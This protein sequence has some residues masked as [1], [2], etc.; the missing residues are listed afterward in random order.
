MNY[1][2]VKLIIFLFLCANSIFASSFANDLYIGVATANITPPK[3]TPMGGYFSPRDVNVV[4]DSLYARAMVIEK[5][6]TKIAFVEVDFVGISKYYIEKAIKLIEKSVGINPKHI[7]I[8][9]THNHTGPVIPNGPLKSSVLSTVEID[10]DRG[11]ILANYLSGVP[12]LIA[13]SVILANSKLQPAKLYFGLTQ[14]SGISF[15]RR[16]FMKDGTVGWNPGVDNPEIVKPT[17]PIDPDVSILYAE[18]LNDQPLLTL[19]N[20]ALHLDE[21]GGS[22]VSADLTNYLSNTLSEVKGKNMV[23][24]FSQGCSG[25]INHLNVHG[26]THQSGNFKARENG[27]ILAGDVIK[28]Y[29]MLK[30]LN[31]NFLDLKDTVIYLPS[32]KITKEDIKWAHN[33]VSDS[34][35]METSFL[36]RVKA[37]KILRVAELKGKP[38]PIKIKIFALGEECVLIG[39]PF[40]VFSGIGRYIK[41]RSPYPYTIVSELTN[42]SNGYLPDMNGYIEGNYEP[43][44]S[45][46]APGSGEILEKEIIK[47]LYELKPKYQRN[48]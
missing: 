26:K 40:E 10:S 3:G 21:V 36:K 17:G 1:I 9:A 31:I 20:F 6:N 13:E 12:Q 14:E 46:V 45:R 32:P 28:T 35:R 23:T 25:N 44:T 18:G 27:T 2:K 11:R 22:D 37:F 30:N 5:N 19:V 15:V 24:I 48:G 34:K 41:E 7:M 39:V 16:F 8:G 33:I 42:G 29:P 43:T 38:R 4:H 47:M